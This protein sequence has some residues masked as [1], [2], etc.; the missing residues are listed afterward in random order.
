MKSLLRL[1]Y[2]STLLFTLFLF[3][4]PTLVIGQD[5]NLTDYQKVAIQDASFTTQ[6]GDTINLSDFEGKV[7]MLDFW[8]TWCAP[9]R[10]VMP[11]LD[12]LVA[13]YPEDFEVIAVSPGWSDSKEDVKAFIEENGYDFNWVYDEGL[14][15]EL[16]IQGIPYKVFIGPDGNVI[17]AQMGIYPGDRNYTETE[18]IITKHRN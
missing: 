2:S 9:C 11:T 6:D 4:A 8:E 1:F 7:V 17:K 13:D 14:A 15:K 12:K 10:K 3:T 18:N 16:K 5:I